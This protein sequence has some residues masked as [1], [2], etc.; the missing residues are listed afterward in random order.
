VRPE[1]DVIVVGAGPAGSAAA[2]SLARK[3]VNVLMLDKA[4]VPGERNT[5][6]G[7]LYGDFPDGWGLSSLVPGFESTAPLERRIIS[8]EVVVLDSPDYERGRTRFYRLS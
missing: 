2:I 3:G 8:H 1:Y 6:G 4:R 7:V 5:T